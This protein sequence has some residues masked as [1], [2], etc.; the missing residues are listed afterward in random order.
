MMGQPSAQ[1]SFPIF[2]NRESCRRRPFVMQLDA[3]LNFLSQPE[4][5]MG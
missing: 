4:Q 3:I 2:P 5:L 1:G